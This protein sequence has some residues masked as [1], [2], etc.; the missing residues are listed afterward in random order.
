MFECLILGDSIAYGTH[1][2][3]PQC[4]SLAKS[5]INSRDWNTRYGNSIS[6][7]DKSYDSVVI[8]LGSNDLR[9]VDT[10]KE[11][12]KIRARVKAKKVFWVVPAIKPRVQDI[13]R[14][15]ANEHGDMII[16]I[17]ILSKDGVHP[18]YNGY[19]EISKYIR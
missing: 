7:T 11:V 10:R 2:V 5:G 16:P 17:T 19:R 18:T 1:Q 4:S 12:E 9:S 8:S 3:K 13:I 14:S 15:V 6:L